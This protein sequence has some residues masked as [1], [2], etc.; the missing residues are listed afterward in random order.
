MIGKFFST[1]ANCLRIP[2]LKSR[3]IFTILMLVVCRVIA[4]VPIPGLDGGALTE[5]L[6]NLAKNNEQ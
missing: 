6:D 5:Y 2:E 3:I 1:F 4:L